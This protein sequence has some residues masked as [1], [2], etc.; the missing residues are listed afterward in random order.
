MLRF[1]LFKGTAPKVLWEKGVCRRS[2]E[3]KSDLR[4]CPLV[5][6]PCWKFGLVIMYPVLARTGEKER[7]RRKKGGGEKKSKGCTLCFYNMATLEIAFGRKDAVGWK[8]PFAGNLFVN[9]LEDSAMNSANL[10]KCTILKWQT[11]FY[12]IW[13]QCCSFRR[14]F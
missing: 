9:R 3:L 7:A 5:W 14:L 1:L 4:S 6:V 13:N 2:K 12:A 8:S 10:S 11:S